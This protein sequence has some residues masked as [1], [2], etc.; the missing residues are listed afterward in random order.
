MSI[1]VHAIG[2]RRPRSDAQVKVRGQ[3]RYACDYPI[4]RMTYAFVVQST[5]AKGRIERIDAE[6]ARA[7]HGVLAVLTHENA[8]RLQPPPGSGDMAILQSNHISYYGQIVAAVV[9]ET[10]EIARYAA[11]LSGSTT[12][13]SRTR[14][15]STSIAP[16]STRPRSSMPAIARHLQRRRRCGLGARAGQGR[17]R[18]HHP[19]V[20]QQPDGDAR[21]NRRLARRRPHS[22]R[23]QSRGLHGPRPDRRAVRLTGRPRAA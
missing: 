17:A 21:H 12:P 13:P 7:V 18:L 8:L 10:L 6:G 20:S 15:S 14:S 22:L 4:E 23:F 3:A 5:I 1:A 16:I 2:T 19:D 9:A 11:T